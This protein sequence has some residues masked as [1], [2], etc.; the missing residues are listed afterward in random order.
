M[1]EAD[2]RRTELIK[3][4]ELVDARASE[5]KTALLETAR[6]EEF[7]AGFTEEINRL[8]REQ[9]AALGATKRELERVN[10]EIQKIIEAIKVGFALPELKTE[11]DALQI[12]KR[13]IMAQLAAA[14][15]PSPPALHPHMAEVFRQKTMQ[16]AAGLEHQ[17]EH[18]TA[19]Q[20]LRGFLDK[21]VIP[22]GDGLLQ[23]VGNLGEMLKAAGGRK[24]AEAVAYGGCGGPQ[25][26]VPAA[27]LGGSV[28]VTTLAFLTEVP[29]VRPSLG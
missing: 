29:D 17:G 19:R 15:D 26:I 18:D 14:D 24:G 12:R 2:F 27:L 6:S 10:R 4:P 21:I 11:M 13:A 7:C 22:P 20:A 1:E 3:L 28:N 5:W 23:V 9:R 25:Q 8:R 16:L